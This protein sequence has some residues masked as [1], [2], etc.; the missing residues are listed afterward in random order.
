MLRQI[1]QPVPKIQSL[2]LISTPILLSTQKKKKIKPEVSDPMWSSPNAIQGIMWVSNYLHQTTQHH[3]PKR[4]YMIMIQETLG[5]NMI[6]KN[7]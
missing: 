7:S 3:N 4:V 5:L 6:K 1:R 2:E